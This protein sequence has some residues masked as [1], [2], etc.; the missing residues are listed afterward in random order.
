MNHFFRFL[1]LILL[2]TQSANAEIKTYVIGVEDYTVYPFQYVEDG[3]YLGKYRLVLDRFAESEG[4][5]FE[6]KP[7]KLAKLYDEFYKGNIDFKFPDNPVWRSLQKTKYQIH[8]SDFI[9]YYIDG[10]FV[11]KSDS[12]NTIKELKVFGVASEIV[13]WVLLKKESKRKIKIVKFSNCGELIPL[14][15]MKKIDA[16]YCNY[17]VMKYLLKDSVVHDEIIFNSDLPYTDN[18]VYMS[19]IKHPELLDKFNKWLN[20]SREFV[21]RETHEKY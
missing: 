15:L 17:D 16:I 9:T 11:R 4:I 14:I 10:L 6:Y 5:K 3:K 2:F 19:T 12:K 20:K 8:Y 13:P 1:V 21:E 18:Y 7:Y